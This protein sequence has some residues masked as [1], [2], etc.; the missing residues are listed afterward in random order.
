LPQL[1]FCHYETH[2][3]EPLFLLIV[4]VVGKKPFFL[5]TIYLVQ[6]LIFK[7]MEHIDYQL[8]FLLIVQVVGQKLLF[9]LG[10]SFVIMKDIS[11][12]LYFF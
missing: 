9:C 6:V 3:A 5:P 11:P 7:G 4:Q 10:L 1:V 8:F 2:V 12:N